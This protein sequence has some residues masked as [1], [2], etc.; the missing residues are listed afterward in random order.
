MFAQGEGGDDDPHRFRSLVAAECTDDQGTE[1][2]I[3]QSAPGF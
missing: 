1:I 3:W 2:S